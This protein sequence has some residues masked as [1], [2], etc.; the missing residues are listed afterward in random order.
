[1]SRYTIQADTEGYQ[2]ELGWDNPLQTF[3]AQ[4]WGPWAD[5]TEEDEQEPCLWIGTQPEALPTVSAL[6]VALAAYVK[7]PLALKV[8]LR[9]DQAVSPGP[10]AFQRATWAM[11]AERSEA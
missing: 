3:W 9:R 4:V 6:D 10:S 5:E 2:I 1:M 8:R 11:F 7:L